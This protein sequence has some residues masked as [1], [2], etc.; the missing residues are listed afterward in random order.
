MSRIR[1]LSALLLIA[2][3]GPL[4]ADEL[5][6]HAV[7]NGGSVISATASTATGEAK[8]VLQDDGKLRISL[9]YGGLA[10]DATG[11]A[12]HTGTR[13][14]NGPAVMPLDVRTNQTVGSLVN[15]EL[16][17]SADVAA[18]MRAGNTYIVIT[19]IDYPSG[20]IRG[21]LIPQP[22]RLPSVPEPE[23]NP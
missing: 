21:Q 4:R 7:L 3:G 19:T 2:A 16:T 23:E 10:S 11:A 15:E 12:L 9:V 13:V 20:A 8:A 18:S 22:M 14:G 5:R 6:L 1:S 17:L